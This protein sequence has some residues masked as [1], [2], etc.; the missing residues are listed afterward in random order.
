M[1]V[2]AQLPGPEP[3]D[4]SIRTYHP[5]DFCAHRV[6]DKKGIGE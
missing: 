3:A 2:I 1:N 5:R 4:M 6:H